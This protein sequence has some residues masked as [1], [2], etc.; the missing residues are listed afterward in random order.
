MQSSSPY[1]QLE[2]PLHSLESKLRKA[3]FCLVVYRIISEKLSTHCSE[4]IV[5]YVAEACQITLLLG[6]KGGFGIL[7]A[8]KS[9]ASLLSDPSHRIQFLVT[10]RH[11]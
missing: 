5:M 10:P 3:A 11:C 2:F 8:V 4:S 1:S 9:R 7:E 6:R